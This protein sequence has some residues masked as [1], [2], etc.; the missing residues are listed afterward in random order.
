M[1]HIKLSTSFVLAAAAIAPVVVAQ[2][3]SQQLSGLAF[4]D[5]IAVRENNGYGTFVTPVLGLSPQEYVGDLEIR[6]DE[7]QQRGRSRVPDRSSRPPPLSSGPVGL[8]V[9]YGMTIRGPL[10]DED[11]L[12]DRHVFLDRHRPIDA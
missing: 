12:L 6:G 3:I 10:T 9:Y 5:D 11:V 8:L 1:V 7:P 2:P 4:V